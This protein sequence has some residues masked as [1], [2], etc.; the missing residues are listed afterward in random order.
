MPT[1]IITMVCLITGSSRGLGREL[2]IYF[3]RKGCR[4]A[5]HCNKSRIEAEDVASQ[6]GESIVLQADVRV[7]Q[8]IK[9][10]VDKV[11]DRWGRVDLL[12]NNAGITK[13]SLLIKTSE[14]DFDDMVDTNLK[15]PFNLIRAVG[16]QMMKQKSG[17]IINIS[18]Y[19][20]VKGKE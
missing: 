18:S 12:V 1:D 5:V 9:D 3:G 13:E 20:G 15:G 16:R 7:Y 2:A 8:D 10:I 19:A 4:I 11:I 17:H 14:Q 6:A